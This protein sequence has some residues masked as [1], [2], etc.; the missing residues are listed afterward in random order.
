MANPSTTALSPAVRHSPLIGFFE[1]V[2]II[3]GS[4]V[5]IMGAAA[6]IGWALNLPFATT[7]T[8]GGY[9]VL[10][11]TALC[12]VLAGVSLTLAALPSHTGR[13]E[14][15]QQTLAALVATIAG[16]TLYEYLRGGES[17]FDLLLFG[18][19]LHQLTRTPAGRMA[20]NTAGTFLLFGLALSSISHD[21][22]KRDFRA[23]LFVA[24]GLLIAL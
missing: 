3:A 23:Q 15:I 13:S 16:L 5:A 7:A 19:R 22:R 21:Q 11:L 2:P 18:H 1:R 12:F 24:P 8:E 6:L 17:R 14:A 10:P 4:A 9:A 20:V